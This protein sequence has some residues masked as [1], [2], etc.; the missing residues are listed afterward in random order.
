MLLPRERQGRNGPPPPVEADPVNGRAQFQHPPS[1]ARRLQDV[2]GAGV[3]RQGLGLLR[4]LVAYL[5]DPRSS[6]LP[7]Q[8]QCRAQ[9]N[10]TGPND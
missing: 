10:G 4:R 8:E 1:K 6:T 7:C 5:D 3:D 2:E 9:A